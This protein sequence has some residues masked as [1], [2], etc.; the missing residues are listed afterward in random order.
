VY[1]VR[2]QTT[3]KERLQDAKPILRPLLSCSS[4]PT[5]VRLLMVPYPHEPALHGAEVGHGERRQPRKTY[6]RRKESSPQHSSQ[7]P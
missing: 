1:S 4:L 3:R 7:H 5:K 2:E 6:Q